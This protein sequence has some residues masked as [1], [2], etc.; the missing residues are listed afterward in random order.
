MAGLK[1]GEIAPE[2]TLKLRR[3]GTILRGSSEVLLQQ[4]QVQPYKAVLI[5][6]LLY[7]ADVSNGPLC[8]IAAW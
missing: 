2:C 1:A 3:S 5:M 8:Q 6:P 7:W 4:L